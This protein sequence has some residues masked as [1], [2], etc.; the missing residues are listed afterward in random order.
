MGRHR[1]GT[2]ASGCDTTSSI[3]TS[4]CAHRVVAQILDNYD[5]K[6]LRADY[7]HNEVLNTISGIEFMRTKWRCAGYAAR[8]QD[9]WTYDTIS[10]HIIKRWTYPLV[11]DLNWAAEDRSTYSLGRDFLYREVE[12]DRLEVV[13]SRKW[14]RARI[15][16]RGWRWRLHP[17][18]VIGKNCTI[19][20]GQPS[21]TR[22]FGT[23]LT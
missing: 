23:A 3:A 14:L 4:M 5:Y 9:L 17:R 10:K 20:A 16:N 12:F 8:V 15:R 2:L 11:P 7:V 13:H 6:D 21:S 19:E 1:K 22:T 18:S